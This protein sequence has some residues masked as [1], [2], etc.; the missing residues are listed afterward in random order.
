[1]KI[2][3]RVK[4]LRRIPAKDLK[5]NPK[6][7]RTHGEAQQNA[8]RGILVEVGY[9]DALLA[10]ETSDGDVMLI[11]GH[12]RAE[13]TPD[14]IVPVLILDVT[15]EEADKI[16][17]TH[18]PLAAM[19]EV[20]D[21]K[22]EDLLKEISVESESLEAMLASL[23]ELNDIDLPVETIIEQD[24][25]PVDRAMELQEQWGTAEGQLWVIEGKQK[26]P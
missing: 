9:A 19:A 3:D 26:H 23:A 2:R 16:L 15:L 6:N 13:I 18:D 4:E 8:M 10:I 14:E 17:A 1:M 11:D 7:W 5:P 22:L 25:P 21:Q 20:D 24:D 12:L